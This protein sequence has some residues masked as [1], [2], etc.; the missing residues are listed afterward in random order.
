[1][2]FVYLDAR[3]AS[4]TKIVDSRECTV[5]RDVEQIV[6]GIGGAKPRQLLLEH[7]VLDLER[8]ALVLELFL[9]DQKIV[10]LLPVP[11]TSKQVFYF[12]YTHNARKASVLFFLA[13]KRGSFG[14]QMGGLVCEFD[15]FLLDGGNLGEHVFLLLLQLVDVRLQRLLLGRVHIDQGLGVQELPVVGALDLGLL[16]LG[17]QLSLD[18]RV[19]LERKTTTTTT[20]NFAFR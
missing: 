11:E 18:D 9:V 10:Q 20:K 6:D 16:Q 15:A 19:A 14:V 17:S 5:R 12:L 1:L 3:Q 4:Q 13:V 7:G 8:V 2:C